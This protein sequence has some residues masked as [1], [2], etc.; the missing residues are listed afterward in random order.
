VLFDLDGT[1]L[2][3]SAIGSVLIESCDRVAALVP[4]LDAPDLVAANTRVFHQYFSEVEPDWN[5]GVISG[6]EVRREA[7]R[8]TLAIV[9]VDDPRLTAEAA[10]IYSKLER[11][12]YRLYRDAGI[13]LE[14]R[15]KGLPTGL[16]TNGASDTQRE[17]LDA[18][19]IAG[20][21][22][23][24]V[25]SGELGIAKPDPAVFA[26]ALTAIG[27]APESCWYVG[28]DLAADVGGANASGLISVWVN[29]TGDERPG[30]SPTPQI[31]VSSLDELRPAY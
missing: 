26:P 17:K 25:V 9:G 22:D 19:G 2:D 6:A 27:A 18:L 15:R 3:G 24:V 5:L 7:W 16:V 1:L 10:A 31:E 4:R 30:G 11:K 28:N 12:S 8:R 29:R 23:C 14:V 13:V 21:F 20:W